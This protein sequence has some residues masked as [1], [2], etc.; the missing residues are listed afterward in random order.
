MKYLLTLFFCINLNEAFCQNNNSTKINVSVYIPVFSK[1]K[2]KSTDKLI[3]YLMPLNADS[4][5]GIQEVLTARRLSENN[6]ELDLP[7]IDYFNIGFSFSGFSENLRCIR[8]Q[9]GKAFED[10]QLYLMLND[11][12]YEK[13]RY[14]PPCLFD[15]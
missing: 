2:I 5:K 4:A 13:H 11:E 14:F 8:N 9:N 3:V 12:K 1:N 15:D 7:N 10:N 6:F